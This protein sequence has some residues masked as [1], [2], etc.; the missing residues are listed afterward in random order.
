MLHP[1]D[2]IAH[3]MASVRPLVEDWLERETAQWVH[4]EGLIQ[5]LYYRAIYGLL[6]VTFMKNDITKKKRIKIKESLY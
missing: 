2:K 4:H 1:T 5:Q 3:F 6:R